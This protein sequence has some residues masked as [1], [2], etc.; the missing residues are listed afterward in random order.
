MTR[1]TTRSHDRR[2]LT[3]GASAVAGNSPRATRIASAVAGR[4]LGRVAHDRAVGGP[5]HDR[6]AAL[7]GRL[8]AEDRERRR[9]GR[10]PARPPRAPSGVRR[11]PA[12]GRRAARR[13]GGRRRAAAGAPASRDRAGRRPAPARPPAGPPDASRSRTRRSAASSRAGGGRPTRPAAASH[14]LRAAGQRRRELGPI[15]H[16]Q[17]RGGGRASAARTSAAKSA[18]VTSTSWPTPQT[19]R[20][21]VGHDRPDDPLVV[22]RPEVLESSR[23][24]GRGSS[25]PA[26]R[27]PGPRPGSAA[28][29]RSTRR[30]A[31]T[32]DSAAPLAL[33]LAGDEDDPGERPAP[34]EHVTDVLP[35]GARRRG[36]DRDRRAA[37]TGSGRLRAA[38]EQALG[39]QPG[40]EL[41]EPDREV[42]HPGRL[43]RLDV[44]L[45]ARPAARTRRPG[46]G[47]RPGAPSAAGTPSGPARRGTRRTGAAPARPSARSRRGR[48]SRS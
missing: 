7:E 18:S 33:D 43:D 17:L 4:R 25:P 12:G 37:A 20:Q 29:W 42:P 35:D 1:T 14:P 6:V 41:L 38:V 21:R 28:T 46:R 27:P 23:R 3:A 5:A 40:L 30:S 11:G 19:T 2:P 9:A 36:D 48:R 47:R 44:E 16:D 15:R 10:R 31:P 39:G 34:G 24:R 32:I 13:G 26:R 45:R 8:R 22:E